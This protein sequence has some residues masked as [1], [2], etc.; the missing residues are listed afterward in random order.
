M[1]ARDI[2]RAHPKMSSAKLARLAGCTSNYVCAT[3]WF[4]K[5]PGYQAKKM[6][7][8]RK[9][10]GYYMRERFQQIGYY[11]DKMRRGNKP[12]KPNP[13]TIKRFGEKAAR[14]LEVAARMA[15]HEPD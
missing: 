3:R 6:R 8:T 7:K 14:G 5:R 2:I 11:E 1:S 10:P 4:D 12:W 15:Y 9:K 13:I